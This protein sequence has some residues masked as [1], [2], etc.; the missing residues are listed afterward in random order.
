MFLQGTIITGEF[1]SSMNEFSLQ[2]VKNFNTESVLKD[3]QINN[4]YHYL[5][6]HQHEDDGQVITLYDQ[7]PIRISQKEINQLICDL[8]RVMSMYN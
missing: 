5:K 2:K 3:N 7:M 8:E 1:D 4:I 6:E